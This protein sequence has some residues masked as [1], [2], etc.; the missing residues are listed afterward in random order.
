M[1]H[2][3]RRLLGCVVRPLLTLLV[4]LI[5]AI[6]FMCVGACAT[7]ESRVRPSGWCEIVT[8]DSTSSTSDNDGDDV[9]DDTPTPSSCEIGMAASIISSEKGKFNGV[10]FIGPSV[11]G[12]GGA[13]CPRNWCL[14]LGVGAPYSDQGW[15]VNDNE[16]YAGV[17][18]D[19]V[20][21]IKG[22]GETQ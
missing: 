20:Q 16:V 22:Q 1:A 12:V 7:V 2:P 14:G 15:F 6:L 19:I 18:I 9:T 3:N 4:I 21:L 13:Y 17:T 8:D 5:A 10:L 11:A